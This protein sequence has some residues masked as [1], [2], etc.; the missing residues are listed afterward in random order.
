M[1]GCGVE[2]RHALGADPDEP[3]ASTQEPYSQPG[4]ER[5]IPLRFVHVRSQS[6]PQL[7][8][9]I[10]QHWDA[11]ARMNAAFRSAGV[12]FTLFS[13]EAYYMPKLAR[14]NRHVNGVCYDCT[15]YFWNQGGNGPVFPEL[16]QVS[17]LGLTASSYDAAK[18]FTLP[19]WM[20]TVTTKYGPAEAV[21]AWVL[22]DAGTTE[23]ES[24]TLGSSYSAG[25][26]QSRI[27]L[28]GHRWLARQYGLAH[29]IGHYLNLPHTFGLVARDPSTHAD[30][31]AADWWDLVFCPGSVLPDGGVTPHQ[32]FHSTAE[33]LAS[34]Q[35]PNDAD[36]G[37]L[38]R[39][40]YNCSVAGD[41]KMS[42]NISK[43]GSPVEV[44]TSDNWEISQGLGATIASPPPG[45]EPY[46]QNLM[47][48]YVP[49]WPSAPDY[50]G[51]NLRL[52][53]AQV[54]FVR[55]TLRY[56]TFTLD[57]RWP[58]YAG[59]RVTLGR[60]PPIRPGLELD[61]NADGLRDL[62]VWEP[63]A[64]GGTGTFKVLLSPSYGS[65]ITFSAGPI[66]SIPVA[67]RFNNDANTD[68]GFFVPGTTGAYNSQAYWTLCYHTAGV[69]QCGSAIPFGE[70]RDV[71][72]TSTNFD[73]NASTGEIALYRPDTRQF[74]WAYYPY[75]YYYSRT[76][77][78]GGQSP[79]NSFV[80]MLD[81]Y[82]G[83]G[84][85]DLAGWDPISSNAWTLPV[86]GSFPYT[87][88]SMPT[89]CIARPDGGTAE[90]RA[91]CVPV[92]GMARTISGVRRAAIVVWDSSTVNW[93]VLWNPG[94]DLSVDSSCYFGG[95]A[96]VPLAFDLLPGSTD[97][98]S[99]IGMFRYKGTAVNS[100]LHFLGGQQSQWCNYSTWH[101]P[102]QGVVSERVRVFVVGDMN[103]DKLPE[104]VHYDQEAGTIKWYLSP[105]YLS[106]GGQVTL[107]NGLAQFL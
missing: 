23:P 42:C 100:I 18:F 106:V 93:K 81:D 87:V 102:Q 75:A 104:V 90:E 68:L 67:G 41:G 105:S 46:G 24:V 51:A 35:C 39:N 82:D 19:E 94:S 76:M 34:T 37:S 48:Y 47:S 103:N 56:E 107:G 44:K 30:T 20:E 14:A 73:A 17:W 11:I 78:N 71:P 101:Y 69:F 4:I 89:S 40:A 85:T 1:T 55:K 66:N 7:G 31:T 38:D 27:V 58:G 16:Q 6:P 54:R 43:P 84:R 21:V 61:F 25:P 62:A 10:P 3:V 88:T 57:P 9:T 53:A 2:D 52:S 79:S 74:F 15:Q 65:V 49:G 45:S 86:S 99:K 72:L 26:H 64:D 83:D 36:F 91:G 70:Q 96:D 59:G 50:E 33:L 77:T 98:V 92:P 97:N 28:L 29:E 12:Q 60:K 22:Y 13:A 5:V 95:T 80:V 32:Y 8:A 63:A